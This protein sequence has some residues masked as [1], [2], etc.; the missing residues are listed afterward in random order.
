MIALPLWKRIWFSYFIYPI[1]SSTS[2]FIFWQ[3]Y[4]ENVLWSHFGLKN[5]TKFSNNGIK[6]LGKHTF[7]WSMVYPDCFGRDFA[8]KGS[9]VQFHGRVKYTFVVLC[10]LW[11][12]GSKQWCL[13]FRKE[14]WHSGW[15]S[16]D[17]RTGCCDWLWCLSRMLSAG[18]WV[19]DAGLFL[20]YLL[21]N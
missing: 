10:C 18:Q 15:A 7:M 6:L 21:H 13:A 12:R 1:G 14:V 3:L 11:R 19:L 20:P 8:S 4:R 17:W 16:K 9:K 5:A 2:H